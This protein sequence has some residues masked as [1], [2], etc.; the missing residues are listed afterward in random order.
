MLLEEAAATDAVATGTTSSQRKAYS[1]V[2][3]AMRQA[4]SAKRQGPRNLFT[5]LEPGVNPALRSTDLG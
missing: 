1:G 3:V 5:L 4:P 2:E